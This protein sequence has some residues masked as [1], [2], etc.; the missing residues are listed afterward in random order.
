MAE[1]YIKTNR[2]GDKFYYKNPEMTILHRTDGPAIEYGDGGKQWIVNGKH[3]RLDGPAFEWANG[4]KVWYVND[5]FIFET[6]KEG[7]ISYRMK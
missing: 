6:N 7:N 1:Q 4:D 5:V 2:Y 3:H